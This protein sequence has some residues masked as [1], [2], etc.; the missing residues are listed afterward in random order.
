MF[1][2]TFALSLDA[3]GRMT[4]PTK[5]RP[6]FAEAE[7]SFVVLTRHPD[8]CLI[9]YSRPAWAEKRQ[10]LADL[11][12]NSRYWQRLFL[13]YAQEIELD[14]AGR[15]L[16]PPE[17][18]AIAGLDKEVTLMGVGRYYELWDAAALK[19]FEEAQSG[20]ALPDSIAG[21]RL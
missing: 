15:V 13:G 10:E 3:K 1:Q 18:R 14:S 2:G 19:K 16:V 6:A 9:M 21:F 4:I 11:T 20:A 17:L 8:G 12:F 5:V 7:G